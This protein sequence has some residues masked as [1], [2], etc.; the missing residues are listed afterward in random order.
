MAENKGIMLYFKDRKYIDKLDDSQKAK[1]LTMLFD[2]AESGN[3]PDFDGDVSLE[4]VFMMFKDSY[5]RQVEHFDEVCQ[6]RSEAGKKGAAKRWGKKEE[7]PESIANAKTDIAKIA[8]AKFAIK[9]NSKNSNEND[10]ENENDNDNDNIFLGDTDVS[11]S[12]GVDAPA[13]S[14]PGKVTAKQVVDLFN[15]IC[16]SYPRV[17]VLSEKRRKAINARLKSM[18]Y[19]LDAFRVLFEKAEMSDFLK[20]RN[21]KDWR[22]TFDWL[23]KDGNMAKVLDGNYDNRPAGGFVGGNGET[24]P[25]WAKGMAEWAAKGETGNN[26]DPMG[27]LSG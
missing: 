6:N 19:S 10:N 27:F 12:T 7:E 5:D 3:V 9:Q 26:N 25:S 18:G 17:T 15:T 14:A 8:N 2:Y 4:L 16:V 23:I 24:I 11:L 13:E 1:F 22:A 21:N 20:G